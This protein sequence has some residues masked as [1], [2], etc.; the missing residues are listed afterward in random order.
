MWGLTYRAD[1]VHLLAHSVCSVGAN[2]QQVKEKRRVQNNDLN[3]VIDKPFHC[4]AEDF[5]IHLW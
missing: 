3:R 4:K 2:K 1:K 5:W